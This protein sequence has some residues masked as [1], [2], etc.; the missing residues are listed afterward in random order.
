MSG[1]DNGTLNSG[2]TA[3]VKQFGSI[4]RGF[5]PPVPTAGVVGDVYIDTLAWFLYERRTTGVDDADPWGHYLW[6][7][8]A[9]YQNTLKWFASSPPGNDFGVTGDYC[10]AW[11]GYA[12][13]GLQPSIYGPKQ[14]SGWAENGEGPGTQIDPTYA[15]SVLP[16]GVLDEGPT[17]AYS[18]STQLIVEGVLTEFI[19]AIPIPNIGGT[20]VQ[21][22]GLQS[23]PTSVTV[24]L[25]P[26]YTAE[27]VREI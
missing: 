13:Y 9:L 24:T 1:F 11:G 3:Q 6:A 25:N 18:S 21:D 22:I 14:T 5:G 17:T 4:L 26:L 20:P 23:R 27:D 7:V 19:L 8:P 16:V 10:L 12:N 15:A 2:I